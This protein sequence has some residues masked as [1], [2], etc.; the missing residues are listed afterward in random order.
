MHCQRV[1]ERS[2]CQSLRQDEGAA[3]SVLDASV[4]A[5][6]PRTPIISG[7]LAEGRVPQPAGHERVPE[8]M[9]KFARSLIRKCAP[10]LAAAPRPCWGQRS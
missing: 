1:F 5:E 4:R 10:L 7:P 8:G 3:S 9:G 2:N 6:T